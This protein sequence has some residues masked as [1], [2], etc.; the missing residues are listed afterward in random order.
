MCNDFPPEIDHGQ[1]EFE[2]KGTYGHFVNGS[3]VK[4]VC[5]GTRHCRDNPDEQDC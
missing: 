3:Q 1:V 4:Y 2:T 5:D